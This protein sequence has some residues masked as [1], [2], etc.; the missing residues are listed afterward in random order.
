MGKLARWLVLLTEFNIDYVAKKVVKGRV[1]ADLLAQNL[2]N[3]EQE[4]ELKFL[5]EHLGVIKI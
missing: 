1:V 2:V 3:D 5:D 4:W